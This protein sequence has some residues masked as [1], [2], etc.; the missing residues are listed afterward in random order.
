MYVCAR[1]RVQAYTARDR[2]R[3]ISRERDQTNERHRWRGERPTDIELAAGHAWG[4]TRALPLPAGD[5]VS[6]RACS[7]RRGAMRPPHMVASLRPP[8]ARFVFMYLM[9]H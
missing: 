9:Q 1:N 5:A 6:A 7:L 4:H 8:V 2:Q 3:E